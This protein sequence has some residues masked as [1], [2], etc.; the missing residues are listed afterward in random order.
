MTGLYP[1]AAG[2]TVNK[3]PLKEDVKTIAEIID[4][5]EYCNGY[6][7]K[8]HPG[9]DTIK[10]RGFDEWVSVEDHYNSSFYN[11]ELPYSDLHNWL[12][13]RGHTPMVMVQLEKKSL[14]MKAGLYLPEDS[15]MAAFLAE[16]AEDFIERNKTGSIY[17]IR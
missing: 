14:Q 15:Q 17:A 8:W 4:D 9:D 2:P 6:L 7:G 16:K 10:Q 13:N 12:I 11:G 3:I 5:N 1:H